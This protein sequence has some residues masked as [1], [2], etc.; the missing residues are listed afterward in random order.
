MSSYIYM[1]ILDSRDLPAR[2]DCECA[3]ARTSS[4]PML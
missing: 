2:S 4:I 1:K 3:G